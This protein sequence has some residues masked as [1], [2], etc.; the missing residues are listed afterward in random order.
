MRGGAR[1][2][3]REHPSADDAARA[4]VDRHGCLADKHGI[5]GFQNLSSEYSHEM[6]NESRISNS[7]PLW[8]L[9]GP[10]HVGNVP[11]TYPVSD[12]WH[13]GHGHDDA[14]DGPGSSPIHR[15]SGRDR[16]PIPNYEIS[17]DYPDTP[18]DW[19]TSKSP[20]TTCFQ[21]AAN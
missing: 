8:E 9:L 18:T 3:A 12:R 20:S 5:Y 19:T 1:P 15:S 4:A 2:N 14:L 11:M 21:K 6:Y 7:R 13:H 17:L 10:A 16:V